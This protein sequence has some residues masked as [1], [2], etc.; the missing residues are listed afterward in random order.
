[1]IQSEV[2]QK[3]IR[4]GK[5]KF[6]QL[7]NTSITKNRE[8]NLTHG[9]VY[10]SH[11]VEAWANAIDDF[12]KSSL[13]L[14]KGI[15]KET[16]VRL[17]L[18]D[19]TTAATIAAKVVFDGISQSRSLTGLA[20]T[21]GGHILDEINFRSL[22]KLHTPLWKAVWRNLKSSPLGHG[23]DVRRDQLK[24]AARKKSIPLLEWT[25]AE[26]IAVGRT[27]IMRGVATTGLFRLKKVTKG[28]RNYW[29][30]DATDECLKQI[31]DITARCEWF[32]P[33]FLPM[34]EPPKEW[35]NIEDGGY[36][37]ERLAFGLVK[38]HKMSAVPGAK[39]ELTA[40]EMPAVY[41]AVNALQST[42]WRIS[43]EMLR[44]CRSLWFETA[45][46]TEGFPPREHI[47]RPTA[48]D[49]LTNPEAWKVWKK[50]A[51][52]LYRRNRS[53][54]GIRIQVR[55]VLQMAGDFVGH[56]LYFPY[57]LDFRGRLY[58]VPQYLNPQG[59][60]L[61]RGLLEFADGCVLGERGMW[62]LSIH[63][64]NSYGFDKVP[65]DERV[66]WCKDNE[67]DIRASVS[68]PVNNRFWAGADSPFQF[69]AAAI[70][71]CRGPESVCRL[72]IA[73]DAT[74]SGIQHFSAMALDETSAREVN[75]I[76]QTKPSDIYRAVATKVVERL[77]EGV[78]K[79]E[80][81]AAE[82]L[83]Y[84]I[85]RS[86]TKRP[87]MVLPYGGTPQS[88]REY[89]EQAVRENAEKGKK[90]KPFQKMGNALAYLTKIVWQVMSEVV[91]GPRKTMDWLREVA[92]TVSKEGLPLV[93]KVPTGFTVVQ[94]R[95]SLTSRKVRTSIGDEFLIRYN[96]ETDR[97]D[98]RRQ[99]Q[100][101]SPNFVHSYDAAALML[102]INACA[103]AG[104]NQFAAIHDS[105]GT[106]AGKMDELTKILREVFVSIYKDT[107]VL[108]DFRR[109]VHPDQSLI[110]PPPAR[111]SLDLEGVKSSL[112]FFA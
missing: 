7:H 34:V 2:D 69:L 54:D 82:W 109:S 74:C 112:Y 53:D 21:I 48:P 47:P 106:V 89:L 41:R 45:L 66:Q 108:E 99:M 6:H 87:V 75:L 49:F 64:A 57:Q 104:I 107:N 22:K 100:G 81:F 52:D 43:D 28:K 31:A 42:P 73:V 58:P 92:S 20:I 98:R 68:D 46:T 11:S 111:G 71:W 44:I 33:L 30:I 12:I 79:G 37:E 76:P 25:K 56:N 15:H 70:N 39:A 16:A 19:S 72:P 23:D 51:G 77:Q 67:Q 40:A 85:D 102:T 50:E 110:P 101:I 4:E 10:V 55:R 59:C 29:N 83:A 86:I 60:D 1:M 26:R 3:A 13:K 27:L 63:L 88:C 61:A 91:V 38:F 94:C 24:R 17:G 32:S 36:R 9:R 80:E 14:P 78:Q 62:W 18:I 95:N 97:I 84:G 35:T 105:Y 5:E 93:W 65:Y 96:D 90:P 8:T 103:D